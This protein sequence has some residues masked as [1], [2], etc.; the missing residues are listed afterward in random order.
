MTLP[1]M[2]SNGIGD[3]LIAMELKWNSG[4]TQSSMSNVRI[5]LLSESEIVEN[6]R[7]DADDAFS[8]V[9]ST[10]IRERYPSAGVSGVLHA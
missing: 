3:G 6:C 8:G 4:N 9:H 10:V 5:T 7:Y 2:R 1:G